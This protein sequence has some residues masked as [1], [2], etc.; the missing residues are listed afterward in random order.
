VKVC[1]VV[2]HVWFD[3]CDFIAKQITAR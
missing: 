3:W 2:E 1:Q